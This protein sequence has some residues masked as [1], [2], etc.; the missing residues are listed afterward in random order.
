MKLLQKIKILIGRNLISSATGRW[1]PK[2]SPEAYYNGDTSF[3]Q[4]GED[5]VALNILI[6]LGHQGP[7]NYVDIGCFHPIQ[8]SNTYYYYLRGG[9]GLVV[10]MNDSYKSEFKR[11][12][13]NDTFIS[14]LVS[15][16]TTEMY[17]SAK[18][19]PMDSIISWDTTE[20]KQLKQP[21]SLSSLLDEHWPENKPISLLDID[22]EGH[23]LEVL[24][25]NSWEKYRP[26]I[27]VLEDFST[28]H[29][30][31][32]LVFMEEMNYTLIA[33]IR[34]AMFF[35]DKLR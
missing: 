17:V 24:R 7:V 34:C 14:E 5:I 16:A 27:V 23:D 21:K 35:V 22:C 15:D 28:S 20:K 32:L 29:Q 4:C 19:S 10:D 3:S 12:R 30:S 33:R 1:Y 31:P 25:S 9:S 18:G 26:K 2:Y 6:Q 13:P 8:Y 11:L